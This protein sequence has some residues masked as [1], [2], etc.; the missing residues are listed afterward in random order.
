MKNVAKLSAFLLTLLGTGCAASQT[1]PQRPWRIEV[2]TSGGITGRGA[3]DYSIASDGKA[4][5]KLFDGRTC[6]FDAPVDRIEALLADARPGE[7]KESYVPENDCCDRISY[8]LVY[9][10]AGRMTATSWIDDPLPM[11][12]DLIALSGAIIGGEATSIRMLAAE[13][14]R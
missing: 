13:R 12:A 10:E 1:A 9:D 8:R 5:A 6:T 11:P 4:T 7:W 3:G 2:T 14:C